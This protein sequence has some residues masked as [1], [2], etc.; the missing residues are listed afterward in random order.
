MKETNIHQARSLK[1]LE[2][3]RTQFFI[4][5]FYNWESC[6]TID[7][8]K[9]TITESIYSENSPSGD[10]FSPSRLG[11][12][13]AKNGMSNHCWTPPHLCM[14][15]VRGVAGSLRVG[16]ACEDLLHPAEGSAWPHSKKLGTQDTLEWTT[17]Q[18]LH[19]SNLMNDKRSQPLDHIF[20]YSE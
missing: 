10:L 12:S 19:T 17:R 20:I 5:V 14:A 8:Y 1:S 6:S 7:A 13:S 2:I 18:A 4:K 9:N 11:V 3:T 16:L 15:P